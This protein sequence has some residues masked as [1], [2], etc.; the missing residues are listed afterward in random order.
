LDRLIKRSGLSEGGDPAAVPGPAAEIEVQNNGA[1][2]PEVSGFLYAADIVTPSTNVTQDEREAAGL[3]EIQANAPTGLGHAAPD[4][5]SLPSPLKG[6]GVDG[7]SSILMGYTYRSRETTSFMQ[8]I[9]LTLRGDPYYLTS[10]NQSAFD[11]GTLAET[12][13]DRTISPAAQKMYFLLTIGSPSKFDF[14]VEDEDE[15]TG[16]WSDSRISGMMSGLYYPV[17]WRNKF[18]NG[19]FSVQMEAV[20]E[21]AVPLQWIRPVRPG[22]EAPNWDDLGVNSNTVSDYIFDANRAALPPD[23]SGNQ[24]DGSPGTQ[25]SRANTASPP[26]AGETARFTN[27][28]RRNLAAVGITVG[29]GPDGTVTEE[30]IR[31]LGSFTPVPRPTGNRQDDAIAA[32]DWAVN[33]GFRIDENAILNE[34]YGTDWNPRA[35][36][37]RG[38][39]EN[40]AFDLNI[41]GGLVEAD[42][43][44]SGYRMDRAAKE[45]EAAGY[46]VVWRSTGH[47]NHLHFEVPGDG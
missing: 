25:T 19:I 20:K 32:R 10:R 7:P 31:K 28:E 16:Y 35:H 37:G 1:Y 38:H 6:V 15:N 11:T 30:E 29:S 23:A 41:G 9:D 13:P 18:S 22:E 3:L 39:A 40:R 8:K 5:R 33:N 26:V 4:T 42:G 27:N 12:T 46:N 14:K 47:Y 43:K 34:Q 21:I 44:Y 2:A 17:N 45:L 24:A 36:E